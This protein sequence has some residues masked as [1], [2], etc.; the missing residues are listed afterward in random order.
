MIVRLSL[1]TIIRYGLEFD[2]EQFGRR[3]AWTFESRMLTGWLPTSLPETQIP[4][5]CFAI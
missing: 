2:P 5:R 1:I 4:F 3:A